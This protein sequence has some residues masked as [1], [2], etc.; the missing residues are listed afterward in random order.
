MIIEISSGGNLL[1]KIRKDFISSNIFVRQKENLDILIFDNYK[2]D[3]KS[4]DY[5]W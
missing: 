3:I 1:M 4:I 5:T 2:L